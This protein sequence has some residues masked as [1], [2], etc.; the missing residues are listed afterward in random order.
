MWEVGALVERDKV[1]MIC[2]KWR[3]RDLVKGPP[4]TQIPA[5]SM[6][7]GRCSRSSLSSRQMAKGCSG[8]FEMLQWNGSDNGTCAGSGG[9]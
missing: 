8:C 1:Q 2:R 3:E 5:R 6:D 7:S 9:Q 4:N